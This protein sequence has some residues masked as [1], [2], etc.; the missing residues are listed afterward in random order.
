MQDTY[1]KFA[2]ENKESDGRCLEWKYSIQAR[3]SR[4]TIDVRESVAG[5][6]GIYCML[7]QRLTAIACGIST[8]A[9]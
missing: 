8:A 1:L 3:V 6:W 2:H 4:V 5:S 7:Y 9:P